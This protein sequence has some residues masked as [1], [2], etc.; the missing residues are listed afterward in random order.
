MRSGG[1]GRPSASASS[2]SA[3]SVLPWSASQRAC[4]RASVSAALRVASAISSRF[5]PRCGTRRWTGPPRRSARNASR[6]AGLGDRLPARRPRAGSSRRGRS[7]ARGSWS[8]PRRR[9]RRAA[10]SS[11]NTSR[12]II[13]PSRITNSWMAAWLSWRARPSRSSSVR[14]K[15]AI[16]WLSIV[17]SM[18]RILSRSD[19]RPLV[20]GPL[21]GRRHL[22]AGAP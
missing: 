16:F 1:P 5:S 14:A 18:A 10:A 17:R 20:V 19:R 2:S 11:R 4:S 22:A 7:T 8:G 6:T 15:A 9:S 21:G 12:P 13:L 3:A